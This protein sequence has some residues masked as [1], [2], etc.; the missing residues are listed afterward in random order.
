M[1]LKENSPEVPVLRKGYILIAL[2]MC[3]IGGALAL[4]ATNLTIMLARHSAG[5]TSICDFNEWI[6]CDAVLSTKFATMFGIPVAWLGFLFYL[7]SV[8]ILIA[9]LFRKDVEKVKGSAAVVLVG[10]S[11]AVLFSVFKAIQLIILKVLCPVCVGMYLV[12]ISL[13]LL[14]LPAIGLSYRKT[15]SF[16]FGYIKSLFGLRSNLGFTPKPVLYSIVAVWMFSLGYVGIRQYEKNMPEIKA[17]EKPF[18]MKDALEE[19]FKQAPVKVNIDPHAPVKGNPEAGVS[20]VEFADFECPACKELADSMQTIWPE[21]NKEA[22]LYFMNYPLDQSINHYM[23]RKLHEN[24]G[25][26]AC[27]GICAQEDGDFWSYYDSLYKNQKEINRKY[28][29]DLAEKHGW[30]KEKFSARMDAPDVIQRVKNDIE[31][32]AEVKIQGTPYMY[33]N[34]RYMKYWYRPDFIKAVIRQE[35]ERKKKSYALQ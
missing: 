6:S 29:L 15:G 9:A 3:I 16:I 2:L 19:H 22:K 17:A 4:Y 32:G 35:V 24:S 25:L 18:I 8:I 11:A 12:N 13:I 23:K 14:L 1:K 5:G 10:A 30:D 20:I 7:W 31:A 26:A 28:L 27:A 33:I 34:G 21:I